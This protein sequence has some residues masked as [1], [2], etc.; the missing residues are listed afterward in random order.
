MTKPI[1]NKTAPE[2]YRFPRQ[3]FVKEDFNSLI[4]QKGYELYH[5]KAI[6]CSCKIKGMDNLSSCKNCGGSGWVFLNKVKTRMVLQRMN[7]ETKF[8][9]WSEEKMGTVSV[10]C[11]D[12]DSI[13]FMD[14]LTLVDGESVHSQNIYPV[15]YNDKLFSYTNYYIKEITDC[16]L[17]IDPNQ[18]LKRLKEN[19]DFTF[20][21]NVF[22]LNGK[23][24]KEDGL[25]LSIRYKHLLTFH[26]ID[27]SRDVMRSFVIN[28]DSGK[29]E[30]LAFPLHGIARRAHY[31]IDYEKFNSNYIFSNDYTP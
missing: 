22:Y 10:S 2:M 1:I 9:E 28:E 30:P 6:R 31:V 23:Y 3:D 4:Y 13:A 16:Y 11:N 12:T 21:N 29:D 17:F 15:L 18:K 19:D 26:V 14:K 5:E 27:S 20:E 7:I 8:K 24:Y 25:R